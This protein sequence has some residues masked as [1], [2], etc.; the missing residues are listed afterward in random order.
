M[1][2]INLYAK[3]N[4]AKSIREHTQ[5]LINQLEL[6]KNSSYRKVIEENIY[7]DEYDFWYLLFICIVFHDLGKSSSNYQYMIR[8]NLKMPLE[9]KFECFNINHSYISP[10]FINFREINIHNRE[11]AIVI[12]QAITN[13]HYRNNI[14]DFKELQD[15]IDYILENDI[16]NK[17]DLIK[18]EVC[19]DIKIRETLNSGYIQFLKTT[20][21]PDHKYYYLYIMLT[22]LLQRI[23]HAASAGKDVEY[24]IDENISKYILDH[25][26]KLRDIQYFCL[27]NR[28]KNIIAIATAG[29]GKTEAAL[30][31]IDK[32]KGLFTLPFRVSINAIYDRVYKLGYKHAGLLHS[33]SFNYQKNKYEDYS[34]DDYNS[35][36]LL[37]KKLTFT[38]VDQI[39]KFPLLY[40]GYER[41]YATLKYSK[42]VID[43]MQA[44][45]PHIAAIIV[46]AIKM[47]HSI[48]GRFMIMTATMPSLY[49]EKLSELGVIDESVA[50]CKFESGNDRHNVRLENMR[51]TDNLDLILHQALNEKVLIIVNT[52]NEAINVYDRLIEINNANNIKLLHSRF[53]QK[54][55]LGLERAIQIFSDNS[56][57]KG[58]WISTN[59]IEVSLDIDF[60]KLHT[61]LSTLDSLFQ[62]FARCNRAGLKPINYY[63]VFIYKNA[64]GLGTVYDRE[65]VDMGLSLLN[66]YI[67][68]KSGVI[69]EIDK[70]KLVEHLYSTKNLKETKF[71]KTFNETLT[72]L[73]SMTSRDLS[74]SEAQNIFRHINTY[75]VIPKS[76]FEEIEGSLIEELISIDISLSKEYINNNI[77]LIDSLK[78]RKKEL[79]NKISNYTVDLS[80]YYIKKDHIKSIS[81]LKNIFILDCIYD[82][83]RGVIL[84]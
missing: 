58:I 40:G 39:F 34:T 62:R 79:L 69:S 1:N 47:I 25:Y 42:V 9:K 53:I 45:D 36:K 31:W 76:I 80:H 19:G 60:D 15:N 3:S 64:S 14:V 41:I 7:S 18:K 28:D 68:N 67:D 38:T 29:R 75:T 51:I 32:D 26:N 82:K 65:I 24:D 71:I 21:G 61:E 57:E 27:N 22:G 55:R 23:D 74:S 56:N 20:I 5:D 77:P 10:A 48:G 72:I 54:D 43:E 66:E 11:I 12:V 78:A 17:L 44:Y 81:S 84:L 2:G 8:K 35:T 33:T 16:S 52:V 59:L 46:K 73:D 70:N 4:P 83:D 63:N 49:I 50:M 13:H 37:S 6:L 30:L